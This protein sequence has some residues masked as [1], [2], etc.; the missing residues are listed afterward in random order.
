MTDAASIREHMEVIGADG[1]HV[2][3]V[4]KVEGQRI[5]LTKRD[6]GEGA[7]RGHHHYIPLSLVAEVEGQKV[8]LSANSDVAVTFEEEKSDPT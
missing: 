3:T 1:V 8:R 7:H 5:K 6:S 4:D 2:G